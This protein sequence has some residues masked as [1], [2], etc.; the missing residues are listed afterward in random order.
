MVRVAH[1]KPVAVYEL[2]FGQTDGAG[3]NDSEFKFSSDGSLVLGV[4]NAPGHARIWNAHTGELVRR[5][6]APNVQ[7]LGRPTFS[8]DGATLAYG[9]WPDRSWNLLCLNTI[10]G[11]AIL[12]EWEEESISQLRFSPDGRL[13][14]ASAPDSDRDSCDSGALFDVAR[15]RVVLNLDPAS[16]DEWDVS[17]SPENPV[18][19]DSVR[20]GAAEYYGSALVWDM[21]TASDA[22]AKV[23]MRIPPRRF[24]ASWSGFGADGAL[25][26]TTGGDG[27]ARIWNSQTG[28]EVVRLDHERHVL[29]GCLNSARSRALTVCTDGSIRLWNIGSLAPVVELKTGLGGEPSAVFSSDGYR[30][31]SSGCNGRVQIRDADTGQVLAETEPHAGPISQLAFIQDDELLVSGCASEVRISETAT[32]A[33]CATFPGRLLALS[34]DHRFLVYGG[35]N[36]T[37][38]ADVRSGQ[39]LWTVRSSARVAAFSPDGLRLLLQ[40]DQS[41]DLL[42]FDTTSG[43]PIGSFASQVQWPNLVSVTFSADGARV[44]LSSVCPRQEAFPGDLPQLVGKLCDSATGQVIASFGTSTV[45]AFSWNRDRFVRAQMDGSVTIHDATCGE[46]VAQFDTCV[47]ETVRPHTIT[48][49]A[50]DTRLLVCLTNGEVVSWTIDAGQQVYL[51]G[52]KLPEIRLAAMSAD[53]SRIITIDRSE[54]DDEVDY[55]EYDVAPEIDE[56]ESA[57]PAGLGKIRIWEASTGY[58][59]AVSPGGLGR[60]RTATFAS[61]GEQVLTLGVD[62]K[63]RLWN[64]ESGA[65]RTLLSAEGVHVEALHVSRDGTAVAGLCDDGTAHIWKTATGELVA[66]LA[67]NGEKPDAFAFYADGT[68]AITVAGSTV[69]VWDMQELAQGSQEMGPST[70]NVCLAQSTVSSQIR[71]CDQ[72]RMFPRGWL[73][74]A[75]HVPEAWVSPESPERQAQVSAVGFS[76]DCGRIVTALAD[77]TVSIR[78]AS[79]GQEVVQLEATD[80]VSQSVA[81]SPDGKRV[82]GGSARG[83]GY[84]WDAATGELIS[85]TQLCDQTAK[86]SDVSFRRDGKR[87]LVWLANATAAVWS[88]DL[89]TQV[90]CF[91]SDDHSILWPIFGADNSDNILALSQLVNHEQKTA[92]YSVTS[93]SGDSGNMVDCVR[94]NADRATTEGFSCFAFNLDGSQL[95]SGSN[96]GAIRL[97]DARS[98]AEL[99][100]HQAQQGGAVSRVEFSPD[101][102]NALAGA[103][104]NSSEIAYLLALN[105]T[106]GDELVRLRT[107]GATSGC[108][109]SLVVCPNG[110]LVATLT[111]QERGFRI[112]EVGSVRGYR[113]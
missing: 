105:L 65:V 86:V 23:V 58:E 36:S 111:E 113:A 17:Y 41:A 42:D 49:S 44:L 51:K 75:I 19:A 62:G 73:S 99:A 103:Y 37:S 63:S 48:F 109:R 81:F 13:L 10:T 102:T 91:Q 107:A 8:D 70:A 71:Q 106:S 60:A 35:V 67:G 64:T 82:V 43:A 84:L 94:L 55:D 87:I 80:H 56:L 30:F 16:V 96:D 12:E 47:D 52:H 100:R 77:K 54:T 25:I 26:M 89:A 72:S 98:G 32:G 34:T 29:Y 20:R 88:A 9:C 50:D 104:S 78:D 68:R 40:A 22:K 93:W 101:G 85:I 112:W 5:F 39:S 61:G 69:S 90:A 66:L 15:R 6:P 11:D 7:L 21:P 27:T 108:I 46:V 3:Y 57:A 74:M 33:V 76:R 31:A 4:E 83:F 92:D 53:G 97:W 1:K 38:V 45:L 24:G 14:F 59:L 18:F 79:T 110:R 28:S 2:E 95:L